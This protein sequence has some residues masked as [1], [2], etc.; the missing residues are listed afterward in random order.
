MKKFL[1]FTSFLLF[2]VCCFSLYGCGGKQV[3]SANI[4]RDDERTGGSLSFVYDDKNRTITFGGE[5][6]Y[7]QYY[8]KSIEKNLTEGNRLGLKVIAPKE[9]KDLSKTT[10]EMNGVTFADIAVKI[11]GESQ[12]F[13]NIYPLVNEN[14]KTIK[15]TILW[16]E[17]VEKQ[18]YTI[19][20][21]D[22]TKLLNKDG[23]E[24]VEIEEK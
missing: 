22:G 17:Q 14:T 23:T 16:D 15:F 18:E 5:G 13:F 7:I 11:N 1:R 2:F 24:S 9:I 3:S 20:I 6:E 4:L 19:I 12:D 8:E 21:K 10:V